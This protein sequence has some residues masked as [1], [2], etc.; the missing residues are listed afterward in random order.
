MCQSSPLARI[1]ETAK[2]L[3]L[4]RYLSIR[5]VLAIAKLFGFGTM[6]VSRENKHVIRGEYSRDGSDDNK[7]TEPG[8]SNIYLADLCVY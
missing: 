7:T 2:V 6:Y 3:T 1:D 8:Q 5:C 4:V